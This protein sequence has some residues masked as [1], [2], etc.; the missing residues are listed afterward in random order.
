MSDKIVSMAKKG[1]STMLI[2]LTVLAAPMALGLETALRILLFPPVFEELRQFI[3][4][5]LTIVAWVLGMLAIAGVWAG[6]AVQR[7]MV[8]KKLNKLPEGSG[9]EERHGAAVG[10]FL[11]TASIPQIPALLCTLAFTFGASLVPV[12]VSIAICTIGVVAQ[13]MRL[14]PLAQA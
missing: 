8:E 9:F 14:K 6:L 5:P 4:E 13:A 3:H 10:V 1:G 12:L 11:L 7:R 2:V